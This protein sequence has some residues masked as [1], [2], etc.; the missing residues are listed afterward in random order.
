MDHPGARPGRTPPSIW[1]RPESG[2]KGLDTLFASSYGDKPAKR[3]GVTI[4]LPGPT[5]DEK[6]Q[7]KKMYDGL[8][9]GT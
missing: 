4:P 8:S 1:L 2:D 9:S 5:E 3:P 6:K 7:A